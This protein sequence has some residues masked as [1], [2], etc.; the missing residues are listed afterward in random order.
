MHENDC[1]MLV[2]RHRQSEEVE[3]RDWS[4]PSG[5]CAGLRMDAATVTLLTQP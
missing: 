1:E 5:G 3:R 4:V 2:D